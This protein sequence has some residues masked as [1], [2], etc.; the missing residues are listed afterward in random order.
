MDRVAFYTLGCKVNQS[1]SGSM[2]AL[3][4][5]AGYQIVDFTQEA[6]VYIINTC[7]VT[8]A[9][10][11]KSRRLIRRAVRQNPR[12]LVAVT[13]CYPQAAREELRKITGVNLIVGMD[14]RSEIIRLLEEARQNGYVDAVETLS[15]DAGFEDLLSG[16][17]GSR[18]RAY[19]KI[20]EGCEQYCTY[21]L[22]PYA[23]GPSRSRPLSGIYREA[24]RL[25]DAG[26]REIVLIGVHLG[27][28]GAEQ[29]G[30][31][32][33]ADAVET[34][35]SAAGQV[36]I[37]LGSLES[38]ELD[39]RL[40]R[41]LRQDERLCRHLH[42]PLQ[43]GCDSV[44]AAMRRPYTSAG[45]TL[46]VD[47]A[48]EML[49]DVAVTTDVI[50]GF[51]GETPAMFDDTCDAVRRLAFSKV[52]IFPFSSRRGT[53]A[54]EFPGK[55]SAEEKA[56]RVRAL[57][58]VAGQVRQN[59]LRGLCGAER[60]VLFEQAAKDGMMSGLSGDYVRIYA[61]LDEKALGEIKRVLLLYP[62]KDGLR[63]NLR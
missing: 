12:A 62:Y 44:L 36:R 55:L 58:R 25:A 4:I 11:G 57:S 14:R 26:F 27:A 42:L 51:P 37:R 60:A 38:A 40:L 47:R 33:L 17:M 9:A 35:L 7:V 30:G 20:Q 49:P 28:Y 56:A 1:D 21:C 15:R 8:E 6:D 22:I 59:F 41:L 54:A 39:E 48:R 24:R 50:V 63:G 3:F 45:F 13:G 31:P 32:R 61:S 16:N 34:V 18:T 52:H 29:P 46:M 23:R 19:L 2:E 10:E 53:A 5:E 43:S